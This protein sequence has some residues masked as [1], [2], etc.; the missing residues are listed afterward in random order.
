MK[1]ELNPEDKKR[2]INNFRTRYGKEEFAVKYKYDDFEIKY[3]TKELFRDNYLIV[4]SLILLLFITIIFGIYI[5]F[6]PILFMSFMY[7]FIHC[8]DIK[9]HN[10]TFVIKKGFIAKKIKFENIIDIKEQE[11]KYQDRAE[12]SFIDRI[13]YHKYINVRFWDNKKKNNIQIPLKMKVLSTKGKLIEENNYH[14][15]DISVLLDN[16]IGKKDIIEGRISSDSLKMYLNIESKN[17]DISVYSRFSDLKYQYANDKKTEILVDEKKYY[18]CDIIKKKELKEYENKL[19][20]DFNLKKVLY[21]ESQN[22]SNDYLEVWIESEEII[23]NKDKLNNSPD[24]YKIKFGFAIFVILITTMLV[25]SGFV[26][27]MNAL[28]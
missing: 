18:L 15:E 2:I 28:K 7:I 9:S 14:V 16:F 23:K 4:I 3:G 11:W 12:R 1:N 8:I 25:L 27:I 17:D 10:Q 20:R 24:F 26:G 21:I 6:F 22:I 13:Y 5:A 19:S